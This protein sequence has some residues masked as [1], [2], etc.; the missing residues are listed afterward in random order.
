MFVRSK[1][2][3][4]DQ[5]MHS[6]ATM[7][8]RKEP[9]P[10]VL[11]FTAGAIAGVSEVTTLYPLDVV[12]TRF[13]QMV[14]QGSQPQYTSVLDCFRKI[15]K[16]EGLPR[17]YRGIMAP[18]VVE[19]PKRAMKFA[20][21][22]EFSNIANRWF[23]DRQGDNKQ[24]IS[25]VTGVCTGITEAILV[26]SSELVKI[27]MQDRAN[28]ALYANTMDCAKR[29]WK[30]EGP[31]AFL[32]GIES[33]IWRN[34]CWNGAYFGV[35]HGIR[36]NLPLFISTQDRSSPS[37]MAS[38]EVVRNFIA[39][40]LGGIFATMVNCPFDVV[41]TRIQSYV[42]SSGQVQLYKWAIPGV[43][44]VAQTEGIKGLYRGFVP[45][46]LRLGPGGGILLVVFDAV[47]TV[48]QKQF[49]CVV[50]QS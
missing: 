45:K 21:Q 6:N 19:A 28:I 12:K 4:H 49:M 30:D 46:V 39:G 33:A 27:R 42:P 10:F 18:I 24:L 37:K 2:P 38:A 47:S 5:S 11:Q 17:L 14:P 43:I 48:L 29:I 34:G 8:A 16:E 3:V 26:S 23:G 7:S 20:S 13:Q 31:L 40:T 1:V 9:L 22:Q 35:I 32:R 44:R 36:A 50:Q 15:V 25:I 41:K